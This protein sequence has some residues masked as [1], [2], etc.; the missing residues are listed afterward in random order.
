MRGQEEISALGWASIARIGLRSDLWN[1][2]KRVAKGQFP[3]L[4]RILADQ[5]AGIGEATSLDEGIQEKY[6]T[7]LY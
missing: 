7:Q 4:G 2:D 6:K 1:P 5:I 3:S